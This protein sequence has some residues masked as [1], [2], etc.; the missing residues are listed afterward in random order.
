MSRPITV[1][2]PAHGGAPTVAALL[3]AL[4]AQARAGEP[5]PVVVVDDASREPLA[6]ALDARR[7]GA[8]DLRIVRRVA[9][10]GPGAARNRGLDEVATPW[11]AFMDA[12][13][14]P[15][16]DWL[17][18]AEALSVA[19]DAPDVIA[20]R[21]IVPTGFGPFEH[22]TDVA[23]DQE[24]HGAGNLLSRTQQLRDD[25]GFDERFYDPARKLHFREDADLRFRLEAAGRRLSYE[26]ELVVEHPPLP[27][28][29]RAPLRLARRYYFDPLLAREHPARFTGFVRARRVGPI[30]LRRARH[31]AALLHAGGAALAVAG[32]A[33]G[34]K[35]ARTIGG[36]AFAAGWALNVAALAWRRT[37]APKEIA[38]LVAVASAVPL[39]YL[40]N[41]Y[42]GVIA[43]RHRPRL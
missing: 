19:A 42:R 41:Y 3:A 35:T 4:D 43:F 38:P 28:S 39:V 2:I 21:V 1:V 8:L 24:Q 36:L 13:E 17:R 14:L 7:F 23:A 5:L 20:G 26:P 27:R 29:F 10:G 32:A 37:V 33:A 40:L 11:T 22:A 9:N 31:D 15:A 18:R 25:G 6:D 34:S 30:P 12:D 16:A